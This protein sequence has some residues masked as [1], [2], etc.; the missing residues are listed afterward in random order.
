VRQPY[1]S[2]CTA[3][4]DWHRS[5]CTV[6]PHSDEDGLPSGELVRQDRGANPGRMMAPSRRCQGVKCPR[7]GA[8]A[9]VR[10]AL[11]RG[12]PWL[13]A[14]RTLEQGGACSRGNGPSNEAA[15]LEGSAPPRTGRTP[16]E[17]GAHP[18]A[19]R[20]L[21]GGIFKRAALVGR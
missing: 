10:G 6:P 16:L 3:S 2:R 14:G 15:P 11:E 8:G 9:R 1:W 19:R 13:R 21:S 17:G 7:T 18:R 5:C 12:G 4:R 20:S